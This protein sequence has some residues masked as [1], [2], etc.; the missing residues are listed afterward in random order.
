MRSL[1]QML[2]NRPG[3]AIVSASTANAANDGPLARVAL[4]RGLRR[5]RTLHR[6]KQSHAAELLKVSQSTISRWE[7]GSQNMEN[8]EARKVEVLVAA[9]LS[10]GADG[11][12]SELI[13]ESG[14]AIH[15]VCDVS[16][17][18][19]ACSRSRQ[20]SFGIA[21]AE[22]IGLSLWRYSTPQLVAQESQLETVGWHDSLWPSPVEFET[23]DNGSTLVPIRPSPC[24]W[25]RMTLSD[26]SAVRGLV[27]L[28][29]VPKEQREGETCSRG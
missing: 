25:T 24:R 23:G 2:L 1:G 14:R 3:E 19:L 20:A 6:V 4:S 11:V 7:D 27:A 10:S 5:W 26:G 22:L 8:S 18:L 12:L 17:R 16:H 21:P 9:R 15:L 29:A 28:A 13:A